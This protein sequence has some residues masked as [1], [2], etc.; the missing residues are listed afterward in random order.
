[1]PAVG[2]FLIGVVGAVMAALYPKLKKVSE[3]LEAEGFTAC[4]DAK[5]VTHLY[6]YRSGKQPLN[7]YI[8]LSGQTKAVIGSGKKAVIMVLCHVDDAKVPNR[9]AKVIKRLEEDFQPGL[10]WIHRRDIFPQCKAVLNKSG[11]KSL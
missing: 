7:H 1:M 11:A 5:D 10:T 6:K 8:K 3:A 4:E 2:F 9:R